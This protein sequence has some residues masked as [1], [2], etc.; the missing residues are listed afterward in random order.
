[1][2]NVLYKYLILN[3]NAG[4]PG[5]GS[6]TTHRHAS[7]NDNASFHG[8]V[9]SVSFEAGTALT[10]KNFYHFLAVEKGIS[11]V[12]AVR[13]FQDFAYQ[14]RKDL[15]ANH[16]IEL[17]GIGVLKRNNNGEVILDAGI[18]TEKYFPAI[19]PV[20]VS[21]KSQVEKGSLAKE[22]ET[23]TETEEEDIIKTDRWWIW[24]TVLAVLAIAIIGLFYWQEST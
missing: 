14:L 5:V 12:D 17:S 10:D 15:Q 16:I 9:N 7:H 8:P 22:D 18:S 13:K 24:A 21:L 11:D 23:I 20:K 3:G 4:I 6:F 1:M 2:L 19:S